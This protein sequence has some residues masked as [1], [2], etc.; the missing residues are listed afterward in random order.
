MLLAFFIALLIC[1]AVAVYSAGECAEATRFVAL[2]GLRLRGRVSAEQFHH[3]QGDGR[4]IA[5]GCT[6]AIFCAA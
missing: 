2:S 4:N 5:G 1:N 3:A 6:H